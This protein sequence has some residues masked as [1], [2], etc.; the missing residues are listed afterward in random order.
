[1]SLERSLNLQELE[2]SNSLYLEKYK[3][4]YF[5]IVVIASVSYR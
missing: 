5:N 3:D 1:M 4:K 2:Q